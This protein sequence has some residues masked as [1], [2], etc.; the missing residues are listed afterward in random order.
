MS[1]N[2]KDKLAGE[3]A[4]FTKQYG[5]RAQKGFDPNDRGYDRKIEDKMKRLKPE[6]LSHLLSDDVTIEKD[7]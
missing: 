2:K 3:I 5:R 7:D 6:D 1:V 4:I